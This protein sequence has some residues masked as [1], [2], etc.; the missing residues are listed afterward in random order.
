MP[1]RGVRLLPEHPGH[2]EHAQA[3]VLEEAGGTEEE[4]TAVKHTITVDSTGRTSLA[5]VRTQDHRQYEASESEDGTITLIPLVKVRV[6]NVPL[7]P[8][9]E[10][11][12][13]R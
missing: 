11:P 10:L 2:Q 13:M 4:R 6:R 5:G 9:P 3:Q 8:Q 7:V 1:V 12:V